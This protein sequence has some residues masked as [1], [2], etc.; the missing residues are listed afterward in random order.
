[1]K[2]FFTIFFL[3]MFIAASILTAQINW[4]K[5]Q[6]PVLT[7]SPSSAWDDMNVNMACVILVGDTFHMWY[8]GNWDNAGSN[9]N[10]IGHATS[11]DG[12]NWSKDTLNPVLLPTPGS[13]DSGCVTQATVLFNN[14]DSLFHM[15]YCGWGTGTYDPGYIGHATSPDGGQ[16]EKDTLNNPV[17]S[18]GSS[19]EWDY[20]G[21]TGPCVLLIDTTY[22]MWYDGWKNL[23]LSGLVGIGYATSSD[24][25]TWIKYDD[26]ATTSPLYAHSDPVL[27]PGTASNWDYPHVRLPNVNY[28]GSTLHMFYGGGS[29]FHYDVGYAYSDNG[30]NWT[31]FSNYPAIQKGTAGSWDDYGVTSGSVMFNQ[32]EDS[33]KIWYSGAS[34]GFSTCQIGYATTPMSLHHVPGNYSTIQ[35]AIDASTEGDVVLVADGTYQENINFKGKAIT[36]AS[37][38][39]LDDDTSHVSNTIIDGSQSTDPDSGSTVYFVSGEDTNSVLCGFTITGGTGTYELD[40]LPQNNWRSGGGIYCASGGTIKNNKIVQNT[41][42][43]GDTTWGGGIIVVLYNDEYLII[44]DNIIS[45]NHSEQF[46][47]WGG[48]IFSYAIGQSHVRLVNN[49][50][51][52][53]VVNALGGVTAGAGFACESNGSS[54]KFTIIGNTISNNLAITTPT[55]NGNYGVGLHIWNSP[56]LLA[57]N[58]IVNNIS[59]TSNSTSGIGMRLILSDDAIIERNIFSGNRA[60]GNGTSYGGGI[61][62]YDCSARIQNNIIVDNH[63]SIGGGF[64]INIFS[65]K[66]EELIA[67]NSRGQ[68]NIKHNFS[69][70]KLISEPVL[71]NNTI[72]E[73]VA[74]IRGGG[75]SSRYS[76]PLLV[77]S[78]SW[79]DST[80]SGAEID[81]A[82]NIIK[83]KIVKKLFITNPP[84]VRI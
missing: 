3:I 83:K 16:W 40:F 57:N 26:P 52:D 82:I 51:S 72:F 54:D 78:I 46:S 27:R 62:L 56:I 4:T 11:I 21:F 71:M 14:S 67:C 69:N 66:N 28:D 24:G 61:Y 63:S 75:I 18:P 5:H 9:N 73:N 49:R 12:I 68:K 15:W 60:F 44:E 41:L 8:D 42:V 38:Y 80:S 81:G 58:K 32:S 77:N 34:N 45:S 43:L 30:I 1:M 10:G 53:N 7:P 36:V 39:Y 79:S 55:S 48:G 31:K 65:K 35:A 59:N 17:L 19:N 84:K 50:I 47:C 33:L 74:T 29:W 20:Y 23:G 22:H 76:N 6:D 13:W 25:I 37:H 2:S 64:R 70:S